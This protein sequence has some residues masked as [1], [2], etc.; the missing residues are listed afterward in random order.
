[1]NFNKLIL[2]SFLSVLFL[3]TCCSKEQ[4]CMDSDAVNFNSLA[5]EDDNSCQ[6]EGRIVFW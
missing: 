6:Y 5:E 3:A 2:L 1:M 4:G